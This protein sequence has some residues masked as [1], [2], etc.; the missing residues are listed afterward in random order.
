MPDTRKT[1]SLR[2]DQ[3]QPTQLYISRGKLAAVQA[4]ARLEAVP[5]KEM[6]GRVVFTDGHTRAF[7]AYLAGRQEIEVYW[8][9]E[10]LDWAAYQVCVD[11]CLVE[12]IH[13]I[14]D[15]TD[16]VLD[17]EQYEILW[18]KR[19]QHMQENLEQGWI[20]QLAES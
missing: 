15:L 6:N 8:E 12:R 1:F 14:A 4:S 16:R 18:H 17:P 7:A 11:W 3:I 9:D 20:A 2:L 19:C 13:S 10:E 5:V